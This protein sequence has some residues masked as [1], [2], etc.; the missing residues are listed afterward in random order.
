MTGSNPSTHRL[1]SNLYYSYQLHFQTAVI[2]L[3]EII[4]EERLLKRI[5]K[6]KTRLAKA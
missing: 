1:G 3:D 2:N 4:R 6:S 5:K